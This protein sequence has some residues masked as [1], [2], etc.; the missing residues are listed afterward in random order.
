MIVEKMAFT[1]KKTGVLHW[2]LRTTQ[3]VL[4]IHKWEVRC[5]IQ[6]MRFNLKRC[7]N[8]ALATSIY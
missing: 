8:L 1:I 2:R 7:I 6:A 5:Y 3:I 4:T